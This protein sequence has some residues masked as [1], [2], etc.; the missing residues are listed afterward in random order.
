MPSQGPITLEIKKEKIEQ[1]NNHVLESIES[2]IKESTPANPPRQR[3][4]ST[5]SNQTATFTNATFDKI[6]NSVNNNN[7]NNKNANSKIAK[8]KFDQKK[9]KEEE[10]KKET[11]AEFSNMNAAALLASKSIKRSTSKSSLTSEH[12]R[13]LTD[14]ETLD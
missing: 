8:S 7:N 12:K 2:V 9:L 11:S 3:T 5:S 14:E 4:L 6:R 10:K 1:L 13:L